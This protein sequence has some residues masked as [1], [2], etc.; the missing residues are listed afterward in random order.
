MGF[1]IRWKPPFA[2]DVRKLD[3]QTKGKLL[4]IHDEIMRNPATPRGDTIKR[5]SHHKK[6]WRYRFDPYRL[7]YGVFPESQVVLLLRVGLRNDIYDQIGYKPDDPGHEVFSEMFE[8]ALDPDQETPGNWR[9]VALLGRE[10]RDDSDDLPYLLTAHLLSE[11]GIPGEYHA[12]L[13]TCRTQD[14][15]QEAPVPDDVILQLVNLMY[16]A[17]ALE[18]TRQPT[19]SAASVADLERI[20]TDDLVS[21]LLALDEDQ[22]AMVDFGVKG[23]T[24]VKGGPGSGKS[25]VA[26]YRINNLVRHHRNALIPPKILFTTYTNALTTVS[27]QLVDRLLN[28]V[29]DSQRAI[30]VDIATLDSVAMRIAGAGRP[31]FEIV[32]QDDIDYALRVAR[33]RFA[34]QSASEAENAF[35]QRAVAA[36]RDDYLWEEF[37]WVIAGRGLQTLDAYLAADRTGRGYAFTGPMRRA[38]WQLYQHSQAFLES[39]NKSTFS[40]VRSLALEDIRSGRY[41]ERYTYVLVDEAQD[42]PPIGIQLALELCEDPAGL[43]MTADACQSLYN[44]GFSWKNVHES[45]HVAGRTRILKR[46]YRTTRQIAEAAASLL[47]QAGDVD[48]EA[49]DQFYVHTDCKPLVYEARDEED[50]IQRVAQYILQSCRD[51]R[52][53][54]GS[55]AVLVPIR[56]LG[57][58]IAIKLNA[59]GVP[60]EFM[61]GKAVDLSAHAVKVMTIQSAK[62]LEFPVVAIPYVEEG[63]LPRALPDE[64]ADDMGKHLEHELRLLYVGCTRSMRRLMVAYRHHSDSR[65]LL[66]GN[67]SLWQNELLQ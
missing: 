53:R 16:E 6:M 5:L 3:K 17:D 40:Q 18:L 26:L 49:L 59:A 47:R 9:D 48:E 4:E 36:L 7:V 67:W 15:L 42:L 13:I 50:M 65:F 64:R 57:E 61:E 41:R 60:A 44:R 22:R 14:Q 35:I 29:D 1:E 33:Q 43:F 12:A 66:D 56:A 46:N 58:K 2:A 45:L 28:D 54:V 37:E 10:K 24:L 52:I 32:K 11:W 31:R 27:R 55:A 63:I 51:L 34:P 38:V 39:V 20:A 21:F 30:K 23:P 8:Q 25:T 62:G 19:L